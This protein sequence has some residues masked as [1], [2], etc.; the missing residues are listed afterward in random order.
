MPNGKREVFFDL[1]GIPRVVETPD[2][3]KAERAG[4]GAAVTA[5]RERANPGEY[6]GFPTDSS[7]KIDTFLQMCSARLAP[8]CPAPS[9]R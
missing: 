1:N 7:G 3:R 6:S 5:A 4:G 8:P 2:R 9:S